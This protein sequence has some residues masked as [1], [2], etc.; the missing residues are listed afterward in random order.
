MISL[1]WDF[2]YICCW[3]QFLSCRS[4]TSSIVRWRGSCMCSLIDQTMLW[5]SSILALVD[6]SL[7][8][9]TCYMR[10][11]YFVSKYYYSRIIIYFGVMFFIYNYITHNSRNLIW[12]IGVGQWYAITRIYNSRNLIWVIG[13]RDDLIRLWSTI[14]E[15]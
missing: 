5:W 1:R 9:F 7:W 8:L 2:W 10:I 6:V 12:V 14:V 4:M 13:H 3:D 11:N 15:I